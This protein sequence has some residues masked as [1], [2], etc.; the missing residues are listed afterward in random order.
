MVSD[1]QTRLK[2]SR[3]LSVSLIIQFHCHHPTHPHPITPS[4]TEREAPTSWS[5]GPLR[6][7]RRASVRGEER[8]TRVCRILWAVVEE[9]AG[10]TFWE[11]G[12]GAEVC[13]LTLTVT[14]VTWGVGK[15]V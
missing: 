5:G 1:G 14:G 13:G 3:S 2:H 7:S 4:Q 15:W 8:E 11:E 6:G 10:A 9:R 12:G